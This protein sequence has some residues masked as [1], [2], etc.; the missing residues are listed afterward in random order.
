[1]SRKAVATRTLT[2]SCK[3]SPPLLPRHPHQCLLQE[4]RI[5]I[6]ERILHFTRQRLEHLYRVQPAG[7]HALLNSRQETEAGSERGNSGRITVPPKGKQRMHKCHRSM[8][9]WHSMPPRRM[10]LQGNER[11]ALDISTCHSS[12]QWGDRSMFTVARGI[13]AKPPRAGVIVR[14]RVAL[15][16]LPTL[17]LHPCTRKPPYS[18]IST[19]PR[20][21]PTCPIELQSGTYCPIM[22]DALGCDS[23]A[24]QSAERFASESTTPASFYPVVS[25]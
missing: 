12:Y 3:E 6:L 13:R 9:V 25:R 1:M 15:C 5:L 19:R 8:H 20:C 18:F 7:T 23:C 22:N 10:W 2:R 4:R 14:V 24:L 11:G 16:E 21:C 17:Y